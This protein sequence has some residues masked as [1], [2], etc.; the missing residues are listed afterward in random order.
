MQTAENYTKTLQREGH[1]P[2]NGRNV[3]TVERVV[4][5]AAGALLAGLAFRSRGTALRA[6]A[7]VLAGGLVARG[8]TGQ[9]GLY[10]MLGINT[11][12]PT[13]AKA[14]LPEEPTPNEM[15]IDDMLDDSFPASDP[16]AY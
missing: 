13:L 15:H 12:C 2:F 1:W 3:H 11:A 9:C 14:K 5:V 8:L 16:P 6:I 4:S 7:S 10:R